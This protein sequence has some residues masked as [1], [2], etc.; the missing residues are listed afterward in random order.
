M[1]SERPGPSGRAYGNLSAWLAKW[2]GKYPK[3]TGWAE[4]DVEETLT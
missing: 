2:G 3:L 4:E 1:L